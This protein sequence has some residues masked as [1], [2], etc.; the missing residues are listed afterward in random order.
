[1]I[2]TSDVT[3][4]IKAA[5]AYRRTTDINNKQRHD[6]IVTKAPS[7]I[8][9]VRSLYRKRH[10]WKL[11]PPTA[12]NREKGVELFT[13]YTRPDENHVTASVRT[14]QVTRNDAR[15]QLT[16]IRSARPSTPS[17]PPTAGRSAARGCAVDPVEE[18]GSPV[19]ACLFFFDPVGRFAQGT[20]TRW[21]YG[22]AGSH[23]TLR[24]TIH[25]LR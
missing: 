13:T 7:R 11:P 23:V 22:A 20:L 5:I 21:P 4:A 14:T 18:C 10:V 12:A 24:H 2:Y 15:E 25:E 8:H 1:M 9:C 19:L 16:L 17:P 3:G 6:D